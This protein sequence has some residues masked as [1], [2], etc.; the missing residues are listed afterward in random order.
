MCSACEAR[1]KWETSLRIRSE[2]V[3]FFFLIFIFKH[4]NT[5]ALPPHLFHPHC[6]TPGRPM[7]MVLWLLIITASWEGDD[8]WK[9]GCPLSWFNRCLGAAVE[10]LSP[11]SSPPII[12]S[13]ETAPGLMLGPFF[14]DVFSGYGSR[15]WGDKKLLVSTLTHME[16][17]RPSKSKNLLLMLT[18]RCESHMTRSWFGYRILPVRSIFSQR[19][20]LLVR[21]HE[22]LSDAHLPPFARFCREEVWAWKH[23]AKL[24]HNSSY[25]NR[26]WFELGMIQGMGLGV[27]EPRNRRDS[28]RSCEMKTLAEVLALVSGAALH[29]ERQE[30]FFSRWGLWGTTARRGFIRKLFA[31]TRM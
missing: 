15:G 19:V 28:P 16:W 8:G 20:E 29:D 11:V 3:F 21:S 2:W 13:V 27:E 5:G 9:Y 12:L 31:W 30:G 17:A 23:F 4:A 18:L 1:L 26:C 6:R 24:L 7:V 22:V 14:S 10:P 25:W